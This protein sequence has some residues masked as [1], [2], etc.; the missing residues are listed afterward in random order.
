MKRVLPVIVM[1]VGCGTSVRTTMVASPLQASPRPLAPRTVESVEM[2]L[3]GPPQ[4]P[5]VDLA[6]LE[7]EQ[8]SSFSMHE[9]PQILGAVRERAAQLGCDG[10]VFRGV[11]NRM[12]GLGDA[13]TLINDE[14]KERKGLVAVCIVYK[15][16]SP[17]EL[18]QIFNSERTQVERNKQRA[19]ESCL[20][21][22]R[23]IGKRADEVH[24]P[25]ERSRIL[26]TVP[27]CGI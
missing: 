26:A 13:E 21:R 9:T 15:E 18:A 4:R 5:Y 3:S 2:F 16:V 24:D 10:I 23:S 12:P 27:V 22:Q 20:D 1:L 11:T 19:Y 17:D 8:T 14:P 6:L 25:R 7:G